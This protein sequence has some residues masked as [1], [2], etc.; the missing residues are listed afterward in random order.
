MN[1]P[2]DIYNV[3]DKVNNTCQTFKAW[4]INPSNQ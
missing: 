4:C 3:Y 2:D 1:S